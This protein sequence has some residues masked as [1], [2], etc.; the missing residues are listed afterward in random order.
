MKNY[1]FKTL[2]LI[3]CLSLLCITGCSK[4]ELNLVENADLSTS[5]YKLGDYMG[6]YTVTDVNG[7]AHTF[8][9]ILKEKKAIVLNFWFI[10]CGPCQMEFPYLQ[11]AYDTYSD[12]VAVIAINP[13]DT[14]E[15]KI[16]KYA[17]Q[18][19]L[20]IPLVMS[21]KD[22]AS[23]FSIEGFPTTVV[24]DRYGQISFI[25]MGSI[26]EDGVFESLFEYF[27][28]D[29]YKQTVVKNISEIK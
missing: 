23:A 21:D 10:N 15:N 24:I 1:S 2:I 8:S 25:H 7:N 16:Q 5:Q 4:S 27:I 17:T 11:K 22:W 29:N 9:E 26:T 6:D 12:D 14:K 20:T 13:I 18:N 28:E 3:I 19:E